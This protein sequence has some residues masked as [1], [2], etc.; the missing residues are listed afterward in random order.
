[1]SYF[2]GG[3]IR[4]LYFLLLLLSSMSCIVNIY[5][6]SWEMVLDYPDYLKNL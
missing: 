2:D 3:K 1:M 6:Y 4:R 5:L